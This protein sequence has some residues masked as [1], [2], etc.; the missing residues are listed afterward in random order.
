LIQEFDSIPWAVKLVLSPET[1]N[2]RLAN[3]YRHNR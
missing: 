1:I 3:I 2:L